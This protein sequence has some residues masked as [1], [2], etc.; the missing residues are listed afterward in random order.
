[1]GEVSNGCHVVV[2]LLGI[3]IKVLPNWLA[4]GL[5]IPVVNMAAWDFQ[6]AFPDE[7]WERQVDNTPM[8]VVRSVIQIL[9]DLNCATDA[10]VQTQ[11]GG[12]L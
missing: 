1:V 6:K 12:N 4:E 9:K 5:N 2:W 11:P 7:H 10:S 3:V 8:Q